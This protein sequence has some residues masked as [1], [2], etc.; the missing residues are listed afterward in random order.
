MLKLFVE[1]TSSIL[2]EGL[3][4]TYLTDSLVP[5][6]KEQLEAAGF[7]GVTIKPMNYV[8]YH[9]AQDNIPEDDNDDPW[10]ATIYVK[11]EV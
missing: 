11:V 8:K 5:K 1:S 10:T 7:H 9:L 2:D 6:L 3:A 4:I